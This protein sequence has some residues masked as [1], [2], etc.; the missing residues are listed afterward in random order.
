MEIYRDVNSMEPMLPDAGRKE[1]SEL[2]QKLTFSIGKLTG[3][4][5]SP[6]VREAISAL[7][8]EMNCY[9]SNLIEGHK[10]L[11]KDI[12][13]VL[14]QETATKE[15]VANQL[16]AQAHIEVESAMMKRIDE[17]DVDVCGSE[18]I[19]WIHKEFYQRLPESMHVAYTKSGKEYRIHPGQLRNFMVDVGY[20][21]PP[22]HD[23]LPKFMGRFHEFYGGNK[24]WASNQLVAIAAA[25][26]R[27]AW[28][29]PFGDGN[30]RVARLHSRA[31][32]KISRLD[33]DGLW[34][35]SRG[36]ARRKSD[37]YRYLQIADGARENDYDGRG[38]LSDRGLSSFC[39]F[40]M[41]TMLDQVQFMD[42]LLNLQDL[43]TRIDRY[44]T[45]E[46]I[47]I[48][49]ADEIRKVV[50][51]LVVDGEFPRERV[52]ELTGK[53][54]TTCVQIIKAGLKEGY[55]DSPS[56]KGKL[57]IA[58]PGKVLPFYFPSLFIDMPVEGER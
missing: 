17:G 1:L 38:N 53:G 5:S 47:H 42:S 46:K 29:H 52:G 37:Y 34:T 32:L 8:Q 35:L 39:M 50:N 55:F 6:I 9:Y 19:C 14:R 23:D 45:F 33:G 36:L 4:V 49:Y 10:T 11:P 51:A 2:S 3:A 26:H 28:I 31:M 16:L 44:F 24:I 54:A 12:A 58:L 56:E 18:F 27:L 43:R 57:R 25:H 30:G 7:V 40:F 22:H 48:G 15:E 13:D 21:T 20:H 41:E